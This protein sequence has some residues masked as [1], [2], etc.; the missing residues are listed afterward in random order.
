MTSIPVFPAV[1]ISNMQ[2]I[3]LDRAIAA[4]DSY[5]ENVEWYFFSDH[6][7]GHIRDYDGG[8][9]GNLIICD[10]K[11]VPLMAKLLT[12]YN[13]TSDSLYSPSTQWKHAGR[14]IENADILFTKTGGRYVAHSERLGAFETGD[15]QL[16]AI[17]RAWLRHCAVLE[18]MK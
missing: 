8:Y 1:D 15:T 11:N 18:G 17:C 2:G 4:R 3:F 14:L 10:T 5:C 16:V 13:K 12:R 7:I 9:C 6:F